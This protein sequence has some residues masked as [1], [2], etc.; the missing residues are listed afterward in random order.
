MIIAADIGN[1]NI[2]I[3]FMKNGKTEKVLRIATDR[4]RTSDEYK[5]LLISFI[6]EEGIDKD[7]IK[8]FIISSV[9]PPLTPIFQSVSEKI[10]YKKAITISND[11][12]LGIKIDVEESHLIGSDRLCDVVG[13]AKIFPQENICVVDFGTATVFN[14]LTKDRCFI[15]GPIAVGIIAAAN[16]L[17]VK[18]AKLPRIALNV[19]QSVIGRNTVEEMQSGVVV[20]LGGMVDRLIGKIEQELGEPLRV[21]A[22]G[23]ISHVMM[24][25]AQRIEEFDDQLTLKGIY[26]IYEHFKGV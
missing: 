9:V 16:A 7:D 5:L 13:A 26:H 1:T 11:M 6:K 21:I 24:G 12:D 14:V 2:V 8:D 22:T 3:G 4:G 17:F 20:G 15:G 18:T 19:P 10:I 25:V 23:G